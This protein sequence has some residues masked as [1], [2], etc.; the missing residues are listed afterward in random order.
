MDY[1]DID[2]LPQDQQIAKLKQIIAE[3]DKVIDNL[4]SKNQTNY[5]SIVDFEEVIT[6]IRTI[7][8]EAR[9]QYTE[10]TP[11]SELKEALITQAI[12]SG[13]SREDIEKKIET[14]LELAKTDPVVKKGLISYLNQEF[15]GQTGSWKE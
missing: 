14:H 6:R 3:K 15:N 1:K 7:I 11:I 5:S 8:K 10:K 12:T 2:I 4:E 9:Y 13:K